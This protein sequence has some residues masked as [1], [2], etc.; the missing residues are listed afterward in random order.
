MQM[1]RIGVK[2]V[3]VL[4]ETKRRKYTVKDIR[5]VERIRELR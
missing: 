4:G 3:R 1:K 2:R 5:V